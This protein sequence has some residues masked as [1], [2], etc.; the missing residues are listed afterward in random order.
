LIYR[1]KYSGVEKTIVDQALRAGIPIPSEFEDAPEILEGCKVY[2]DAFVSLDTE[3]SHGMGFTAIPWSKIKNYCDHYGF[4]IHDTEDFLNI[5]TDLDYEY[6]L[7]LSSK[8]GK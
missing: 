1:S 4:N 7:Y 2:Y 5:I 3:R 6:I 8:Q